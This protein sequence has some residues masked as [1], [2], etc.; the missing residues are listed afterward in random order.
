MRNAQC[1]M[2]TVAFAQRFNAAV[3]GLTAFV[4]LLTCSASG[5][6][7]EIRVLASNGV[8]SAMEDLVPQC[9]R[10]TG[11]RLAMRFNSSTSLKQSIENGE[12]FHVDRKRTRLNS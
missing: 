1:R 3:V 11:R 10:A 12:A 2:Q 6:Q 8:K 5:Q 9:E 4:V 7:T